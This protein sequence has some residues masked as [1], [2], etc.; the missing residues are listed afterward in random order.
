[1]TPQ[2]EKTELSI[3]IMPLLDSAP[4]VWAW[5]RGFFSYVGLEVELA[6]EVS[7]ASLRDRLAYDALD[8]AQCLAPMIL[9]A[10]LAADQVGVPFVS[11]LTLS[12][13][14]SAITLS[15]SLITKLSIQPQMTP[16]QSALRVADYLQ[17]GHSLKLAHV[18]QFSMH[19]YLLHEW[20]SL[21]NLDRDI[22]NL[23]FQT[24]PP[25]QMLDKLQINAI[26]GFCVGEPW[27]TAAESSGIGMVVTN[28]QE[29]C[30]YGADKVL[31]VT[32]KWAQQNPNTHR[33]MI[34]AILMAQHELSSGTHYTTL[35]KVMDELNI[36]KLPESWL[37]A[38]LE[39][40]SAGKPAPFLTGEQARPRANDYAWAALQ[41][42]RW[43]QWQQPVDIAAAAYEACDH[44]CFDDAYKALHPQYDQLKLESLQPDYL[45]NN[46][47]NKYLIEK[48][49][50]AEQA[51]YL[52]NS[53]TDSKA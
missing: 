2:L 38:A 22:A 18:F 41:M 26:D 14:W 11:A 16:A 3:G 45:N 52:T 7:W 50:D 27:N 31:G 28:A 51:L 25:A 1:M 9:A 47:A 40:A 30:P 49:F 10:N 32:Q 17:S 12:E 24:I 48:G 34:K 5:Y 36:L 37:S 33:A 8:A 29:L 23:E 15:K 20:L 44:R 39:G 13:N 43:G 42:L 6:R 19:N 4:I 46:E 35:V 21:T 53:L